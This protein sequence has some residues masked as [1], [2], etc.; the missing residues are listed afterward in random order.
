MERFG[1]QLFTGESCEFKA[2]TSCETTSQQYD[3]VHESF[4]V[5]GGTCRQTFDVNTTQYHS[6]CDCS[7]AQ[8]PGLQVEVWGDY[9]QVLKQKQRQPARE[10]AQDRRVIT[11]FIVVVIIIFV[12]SAIV[13]LV[14]GYKRAQKEAGFDRQEVMMN[15]NGPATPTIADLE[16]NEDGQFT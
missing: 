15:D 16:H 6:P 7:T 10:S 12:C 8:V 14:M 2:F 5:N 1:I 9:C 11:S 3:V 13:F 4:C